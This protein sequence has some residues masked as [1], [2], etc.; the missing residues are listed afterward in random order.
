MKFIDFF[1][2]KNPN[3]IKAYLLL[4]D[5]G[6]WPVNFAKEVDQSDRIHWYIFAM[7]KCSEAWLEYVDYE[8]KC[9]T[10]F[11]PIN[12]VDKDVDTKKLADLVI[13]EINKRIRNGRIHT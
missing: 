9:K 10:E 12:S 3:H 6:Y 1:D 2:P 11:I 13:K 5:K 7:A 8:K 4:M